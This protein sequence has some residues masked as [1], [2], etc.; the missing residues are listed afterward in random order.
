MSHKLSK[1][2]AVVAMT[3]GLAGFG[4]TAATTVAS[5]ATPPGTCT[6]YNAAGTW[7]VSQ[8]NI[9]STPDFTM[10]LTQ[11]GTTVGGSASIPSLGLSSQSL[12]GTLVG[13]AL[14]VLITWSSASAGDYTGTV[15]L[16]AISNGQ[17][18]DVNQPI[19]PADQIV[20]WTA[21]G[22]ATCASSTAT[23]TSKDQCKNGGWQNSNLVD[24]SGNPFKNQGDCVSFVASGGKSDPSHS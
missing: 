2:L 22:T 13:N 9:S 15:S 14:H 5:A 16:N 3:G 8:S 19:P 1:T 24:A 4:A 6:Q 18:Y 23:P 21:A 7:N 12:S 20:T 17:T 10:T 11:T